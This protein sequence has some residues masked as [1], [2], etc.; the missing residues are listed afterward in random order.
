MP[1]RDTAQSTA[2]RAS[3]G[4]L[5]SGPLLLVA[6]A[7][8]VM[9]DP[10]SSVAYAVEAAL[11]ALNGDLALLLPTMALV[12]AIIAL[13]IV[14]YRQLVARYPQGGGASA[15]VGEAFG[16]GWSFVPVGA[17]VVDFV[18]TIAISA[19]A[20]ASAVIAYAPALAA[21]RLP[22]ALGLVVVVGGLTWFGH[23]GRLLFAVLTIAFIVVAVAVLVFG[24]WAQPD[25]TGTITESAGRSAPLAIVLAFPV[26]MALATGVEA[27]SSAIAQLGQLDDAGRRRFGQVTLVLTLIVVGTITLGL[28]A[29][30]TRLRIG[31]PPAESTQIAEL[32]RVAAPAPLFAA[33][34][35]VTALLLL[36]AA[37]SS[38]QA[39][40]GLLK[41]L[42]GE[43]GS[44]GERVGILPTALG[45]TNRH[46]TPYW[47]VLVF[48]LLAGA[49]TAVAG[50]NDQEL[51]LFYAVS[52]FLSFLAGLL[53]MA[54]F[55]WR[56]RRIGSLLLNALGALVV[57]FTLVAN[58]SRG[59]PIVSLVVA[60]LIAA[61]LFVLWVRN[62]RPP[63]IR[64]I[65]AESEQEE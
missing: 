52:V 35:L 2:V 8:A 59:T 54:R 38:F 49:V 43:R 62:G 16:D 57:A 33:F 40:P 37:S 34:Q 64:N 7:F 25:P 48:L 44:G 1:T 58:L 27:P 65:A 55:S 36:S 5:A 3:S 53:A 20:G 42:A 47:G 11:R 45:R 61:G 6:F 31:I 15:A 39:G 10:V 50:G 30:A 26:A 17:L 12:V 9:A 28:A 56:E 13:V 41:A 14:N 21:Y 46:H 29:E 22:L 51:V 18:L 24:L 60:L 23:L 4:R 19:S 32:A 63:G